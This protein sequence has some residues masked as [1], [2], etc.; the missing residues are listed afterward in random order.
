M[1]RNA[2][3]LVLHESAATAD[4]LLGNSPRAAIGLVTVQQHLQASGSFD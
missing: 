1:Q 3:A 4:L 2:A